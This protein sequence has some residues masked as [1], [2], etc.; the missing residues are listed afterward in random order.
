MAAAPCI[1]DGMGSR[2][3]GWAEAWPA[4]LLHPASTATRPSAETVH[5]IARRVC[6]LTAALNL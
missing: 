2:E 5:L 1:P 3:R 6:E 4:A